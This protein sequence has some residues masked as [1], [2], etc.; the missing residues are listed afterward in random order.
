MSKDSRTDGREEA[1]RQRV[2]FGGRRTKLQLSAEDKKGLKDNGWTERWV[3]DKDG[4]IQQAQAGGY[5]FVTPEEAPSI[6]QFSLTKGSDDLNGKVSLIVSKGASEPIT[7]YLMKIQTKYY[8]ED[9]IAK[10]QAHRNMDASLSAGQPGGN[11]V[12]NQYVPDGHVNE[13]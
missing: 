13:I 1:P 2:P 12:E 5:V 4:R 6:G 10:E 8:K 11:V 3:N 7:A 9:Q